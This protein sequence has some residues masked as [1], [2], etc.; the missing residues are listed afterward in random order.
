MSFPSPRPV[1][2]R[3]RLF[4]VSTTIATAACLAVARIPGSAQ[5]FDGLMPPDNPVAGS[6]DRARPAFN[7]ASRPDVLD[8]ESSLQRADLVVAARL[9]EVTESRVVQGGRN[10]QVTQQYRFEPV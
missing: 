4:A 10:V 8:L 6:P 1:A 3:R 9:V 5:E 2:A 7:L